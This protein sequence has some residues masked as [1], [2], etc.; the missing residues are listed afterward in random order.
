MADADQIAAALAD[1]GLL[2]ERVVL[3]RL[4]LHPGDSVRLGNAAF[5]VRGT[6]LS[7]PDQSSGARS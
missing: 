3:D 1:H 6:L 4:G 2:A 5:T 7:E